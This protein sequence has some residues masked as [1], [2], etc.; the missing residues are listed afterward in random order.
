[1]PQQQMLFCEIMYR[2]LISWGNSRW[3]EARAI[4]TNDGRVVMDFLKFHI[5]CRISVSKVLINDQGIHFC[6]RVMA[7]LL[8]K[9]G[10]V[11]R[12]VTAYH[13]QSCYKRWRI[14]TRMI[15]A[16][17]WRTLCG[18]IGQHTRLR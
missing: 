10:V 3:V 4:K 17:S 8:E 5:F 14:L 15:G 2:V 13:P 18:H 7:T 16:D 9:Y 11:H 12:V 6:N 1:M